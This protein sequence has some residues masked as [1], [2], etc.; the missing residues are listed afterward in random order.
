MLIRRWKKRRQWAQQQHRGDGFDS[1]DD[2]DPYYNEP[3]GRGGAGG[4]HPHQSPRHHNNKHNG[5]N[6]NKHNQQQHQHHRHHYNPDHSEPMR[7]NRSNRR[8]IWYD[9]D[10]T[11]WYPDMRIKYVIQKIIMEGSQQSKRHSS[12]T[13]YSRQFQKLKKS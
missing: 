1:D 5:H 10:A 11:N 2:T 6:R 7:R 4:Y 3:I 12:S 13:G 8:T 9:S